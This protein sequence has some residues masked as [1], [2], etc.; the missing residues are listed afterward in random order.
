MN[1]FVMATVF[2][3]TL[4]ASAGLRAADAGPMAC[5]VLSDAEAARLVGGPLGETDKLGAPASAQNGN[6]R[7]S[8]C[9]RFPKGY[10][11]ETA[12]GPP[13]RGVLVELHTLPTAAAARRFYEGV[14]DMHMDNARSP[15]AR[16]DAA[17]VATRDIGEAA[18]LKPTTLADPA[19]R[20]VTLTFLKGSTVASVQVWKT[21]APVDAVARAAAV[22]VAGRLP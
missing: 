3:A 16:A 14:L 5:A 2:T 4:A 6:D 10:H 13:E 20:I 19:V 18:Y 17:V 8:A 1:R 22:Q 15:Q 21:A 12:D 7:K 11:I 9:G